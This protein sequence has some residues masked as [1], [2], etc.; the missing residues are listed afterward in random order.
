MPASA[1][2]RLPPALIVHERPHL[3][4]AL[5][6]GQPVTLLSPPG[7][8]LYAG[9]LWWQALL[10]DAGFAGPSLLDCADAAGRAIEALR[11]GLPGIILDRAAPAFARVAL[12]AAETG[13]ILLD[14]APP[15]LDL[16][17]R[18]ADG[19]LASWL[20]GADNPA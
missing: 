6:A 4:R 20:D 9:C 16:G 18:I 19:R 15:A 12:I 10:A 1:T 17:E 7:F 14:R 2:E 3:E 8:A 13:V 11:I 5:A